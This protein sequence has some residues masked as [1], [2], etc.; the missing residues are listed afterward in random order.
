MSSKRLITH[1]RHVDLAVPNFDVQRDFYANQWG[2][3]EVASD[4]G[5]S[6][7]AAEGSAESYAVRIR[8]SENKGIE[9]I[10]LGAADRASVDTLAEQLGA[11]GVTIVSEPAEL[12]GPFGGY[13]VQFFDCDGRVVEVSTEVQERTARNLE[14]GESIPA[15]LSHCV[16]NS[17]DL[18]ATAKWYE[19]H[20]GFA[21]SDRLVA[22]EMGTL[23]IF[24]RCNDT[25]HSIAIA[26]APHASL[27]H[28]S[29][30]MRGI[31]EYMRATGRLLRAGTDL[32][33]GPGRHKAGDNTF[34]YFLDPSGNTMEFT[35]EM[36]RVEEAT[37][38]AQEHDVT[39][40]STQD[41]WGTAAPMG[42][43]IA[44]KSFNQPDACLFVAPVV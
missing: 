32:I 24:L 38:V 19:K 18:V 28:L 8:K 4:S 37:W 17:T 1:L 16:V 2:L 15:Q 25:H 41:Q 36:E 34:A 12:T 33:W 23:M 22:P 7:L 21:E 14:E 35:T 11:A 42:P 13:G 10:A 29:F 6:Y 44:G 9:T 20:L 43:E 3:T 39:Q 40:P 26:G 30:E 31:D 27:H 5:I